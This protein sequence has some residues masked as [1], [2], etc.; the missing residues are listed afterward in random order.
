MSF[1]RRLLLL[2]GIGGTVALL[3][4][5]GAFLAENRLD[6]W[7]DTPGPLDAPV[8]VVLRK[9]SGL[10]AIAGALEQA[11]V[12]DSR[13]MLSVAARL[14][15]R[16]RELQAGEYRFE[17]GITPDQAL[18]KLE[19]GERVERRLTIPE[20]ITIQAAWRLL[21][22]EDKLAGELPP[23]PDE[24]R[25]L[26]ET[27]FF[28][29]GEE[30]SALAG[31]MRASMARAIDEL[32]AKRRPDLPF[33][34]VE[35]WLTLASIIEKETALPDE[36]PL[37]AAVYVNRLRKGMPLQA[38]PTVIYAI[39][40]GKADLGREL[41]RKDLAEDDPYN[42]Y[43]NRGLPPGPIALPGR[44]ALAAALDPADVP[45]VFFV[46]DGKGGHT[47]ATTL[48]EHNA[49]V[50]AWRRLRSAQD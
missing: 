44:A 40:R 42:T 45:Y 48:D 36:Y 28:E 32:W 12:I 22:D 15:G 6:R 29:R 49:N 4:V 17:P 11:R 19:R 21:A 3:A 14:R 1:G 30:R 39:T 16:D 34:T 5:G 10:S 27:Y 37:V 18:Q 47:F 26:P 46:A 13:T 24:G 41:T 8:E 7:L 20:G 50:R 2:L 35:Q 23:M 25:I 9:G 33:D 43:K 31:R 38:D